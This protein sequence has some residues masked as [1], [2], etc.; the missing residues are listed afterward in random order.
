EQTLGT[1]FIECLDW[2]FDVQHIAAQTRLLRNLD[3]SKNIVLVCME[4]D[5]L[6]WP[7]WQR[8]HSD[9]AQ[10]I[11]KTIENVLNK[12]QGQQVKAVLAGHSGGGS[13]IFGFID[14]FD[15]IPSWVERI[16]FL[17]GNYGFSDD[18]HHGEKLLAWLQANPNTHLVVIAYD[19]RRI[20]LGGK[21]VV[22]T[23]GG[24]YRASHRML[25]CFEKRVCFQR[26]S[27]G[28]IDIYKAFIDHPN[29][30]TKNKP[31]KNNASYITFL[32]HRNP[33]N[34][35]LH[36]ALVDEMNG[37]LEALTLGTNLEGKWGKFGSPR[38]YNKWIQPTAPVNIP[39]RS[40][41]AAG[42]MVIMNSIS[43]M[44]LADRE[45]TLFIE[46]ISGNIPEFLRK[47]K[48]VSFK[49]TDTIGKK[50]SVC[51]YVMPDYLAVG[52]NKDFV[53]VPL[54]PMT[55][56]SVADFFNCSLPTRKMVDE[57]Y[58]Q[59]EVKLEPKP[60]SER[61]EAVETFIK[62]NSIIEAQRR[63]K[64]LGALVAGIKKDVTITNLPKNRQD[65]VAIYGWHK[66]DGTPI[67]PLTTVHIN[68]YVDY[69]HGIRLIKRTVLI[70][71]K[72]HDIRDVL[73]D[74]ILHSLLSD[75]GPIIK[76]F[77][78]AEAHPIKK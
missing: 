40:E 19:D 5:E 21:L 46:L 67:Q 2:H 8:K 28:E 45:K 33:L 9:S 64:P 1:A 31:T 72:P 51:F 16:V 26:S 77:Y 49:A 42:G 7:T 73:K 30:R 35:I 74:P 11:Y 43:D 6:S 44:P 54:T 52:S 10:V 65:H 57:I 47:F 58:R 53:R 24:T 12:M 20:T 48:T 3:K 59:A 39:A 75:E 22:G 70:D 69:S 4:T 32:I 34:K 76:P 17:D 78:D 14:A 15:S 71:G 63:Q 61:R 68:W 25:S 38:A 23:S 36:T 50:H 27:L 29:V 55:A 18:K 37:Y 13:M 60:L 66:L 41:R 56:Q 62:H